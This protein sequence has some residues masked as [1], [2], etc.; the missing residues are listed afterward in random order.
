MLYI[1]HSY[2]SLRYGTL[3][4]EQLV[5][6]AKRYSLKRLLLA[7]IN[8]VTGV[9]AFVKACA[10]NDIQPD[11][12]VTVANGNRIVYY[13]LALNRNGFRVIN[14]YL[15]HYH[16]L[17]MSYPEEAPELPGV[18][19]LLPFTYTQEVPDFDSWRVALTIN[20]E[21][22]LVTSRWSKY[23]S[24]IY[25][26]QRVVYS[27]SLGLD[28]HVH[29]RAI[30]NNLVLSKLDPAMMAPSNSF[31]LSPE[32]VIE[33]F[34]RVSDLF[35]NLEDQYRERE[36]GMDFT[37][38]KNKKIFTD[39]EAND[40]QLLRR[41]S[42]EGMIWR[43]GEDHK[44]AERRV[45][46][47]LEMIGRL[48]FRSYFL[49]AWDMIMFSKSQ[50]FYH[51]G[52]GSGANSVVAYCLGITDVDPIELDLYFERFINPKRTSPPDFDID[53]SWKE[54]DRVLDYLFSKY[55][56]R[57]IA[58]LGTMSTFRDSSMYRELGKVYGL[59]VEEIDRLAEH[60]AKEARESEIARQIV[61]LAERLRD[62]PNMR[63]I[64]AGGVLITEEPITNY[65][66]LD[67]PP[68]GYAT[69]QWDMYTAEE[70]RFEK[71]DVLSQRGIG[72]IKDAVLEVKRNRGIEI[73]I[74]QVS[75]FK[76][77]PVVRAL[78]RSGETIGCFY[79]ESPAMRQLIKKLRCEDYLTLVAASSII[80]PGVA[81][82]GMMKEY[83]WRFH[84]PESFEYIH[85]VMK[86]QLR[87]TYGVMVYQEDVLKVCH[88][89]AGLDLAEAD[90]LR[91]AMSG[92][93]RG[94]EEMKRIETRFFEGCKQLG[95]SEE[96]AKEV[97]RQI[98]SF[99]GYS[100]S[101]AH[102]A[103]YAVESFQSLYL[104]AYYPLEFM[105]GVINNFGGFYRS[106]VY[107][108]EAVRLGG[109]VELPCV[110]HSLYYT[111]I[112]GNTLYAGFVHM[113]NLDSALAHLIVEERTKRGL[114]KSLEDFIDR[115]K[116]KQEQITILIRIGAL[117]FTG[118]QKAALLWEAYQFLTMP[119]S[120]SSMLLLFEK[121]K[122]RFR[123]PVLEASVL[124]DAYD[125][126]LILEFPLSVSYFD[127][128][129]TSFRGEIKSN[130]MI[131]CIGKM[132]RMLGRLVTIK[133]VRTSKGELM[134]FGTFCDVD[135]NLFDTVHF[136][137]SLKGYPFRGGGVYL[138][139]G[140]ITEE[141][142]QPSMTVLKM[143]KM[144]IKPDPREK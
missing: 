126:L 141:F 124:E 65:T 123:L 51:V 31:F 36:F 7:D 138:L 19:T 133:Y 80:R 85:P 73:D 62:F 55:G 4:P 103:S 121:E 97:W 64:H 117:R 76:N 105:V 77:D 125:E 44:E 20:E 111:T 29:L 46:Y 144:P 119:E 47:E 67:L 136:P 15:T 114:Y 95:R 135:G 82:S 3:S 84:H 12:G 113:K 63:S 24:R 66:A 68:K 83:I 101:K 75:L 41:L 127:L 2:F 11:I 45:N 52:R 92:K 49:I 100:F 70:L 96:V 54:R 110:N 60:P 112:E 40:D 108:N 16:L 98:A 106:W 116:P 120:V 34:D 23:K 99:A 30:D 5:D 35:I 137:N 143:A 42:R 61:L 38:V 27:D 57:Y 28:L 56:E 93:F 87:E 21:R 131:D 25:P 13:L 71:L 18:L 37:T 22:R 39:S 48:G 129:Q 122:K 134:H 43:Y 50:G 86:D 89:F 58:L 142:G 130:E 33:G 107:F 32:D 88:H 78:L 26:I 128:L 1:C 81:K 69:T 8:N 140:E 139:L 104:K 132:V 90:I 118:K 72:H 79:I 53:Y 9:P 6:I 14:D 115:V 74:H 10:M 59:P 17:S 109:K 102:S 94:N 91:R